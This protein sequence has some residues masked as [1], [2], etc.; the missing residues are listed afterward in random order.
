MS[1]GWRKTTGLARMRRE[2][3]ARAGW[4]A[5]ITPLNG[6][7]SLKNVA[8]YVPLTY[9]YWS[10]AGERVKAAELLGSGGCR[11][12]HSTSDRI[13]RPF[14]KLVSPGKRPQLALRRT[15]FSL[16]KCHRFSSWTHRAPGLRRRDDAWGTGRGERSSVDNARVSRAN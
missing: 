14:A 15:T 9:C 12:R 13:R 6:P 1:S 16:K 5:V 4:Q 8:H 2:S 3:L 10:R 7:S 11:W